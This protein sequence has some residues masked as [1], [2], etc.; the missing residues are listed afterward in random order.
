M[1]VENNYFKLLE[2]FW[3]PLKTKRYKI[4]L[5]FQISHLSI[6]KPFLKH[7]RMIKFLKYSETF[8]NEVQRLESLTIFKIEYGEGILFINLRIL[9]YLIRNLKQMR[10]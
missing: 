4:K 6:L 8:S 10:R 5:P 1:R 9:R 2:T 3:P 7:D